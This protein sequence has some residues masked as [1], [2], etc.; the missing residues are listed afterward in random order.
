[1]GTRDGK[2]SKNETPKRRPP[3]FSL[4]L[5]SPGIV[6]MPARLYLLLAA[7][8]LGLVQAQAFCKEVCLYSRLDGDKVQFRMEVEADKVF[9]V[10][11]LIPCTS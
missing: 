4:T 9:L 3:W 7:C 8:M 5:A 2:K 11:F 6:K 10:S 1:M